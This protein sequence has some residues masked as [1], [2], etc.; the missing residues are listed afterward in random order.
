M[1][2]AGAQPTFQPEEYD[3]LVYPGFLRRQA[4]EGQSACCIK[5]CCTPSP[6]NRASQMARWNEDGSW[7][8]PRQSRES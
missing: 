3:Q 8:V 5:I 4:S 1:S 7:R 6:R 2:R